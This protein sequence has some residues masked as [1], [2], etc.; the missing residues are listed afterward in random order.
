LIIQL[1][2]KSPFTTRRWFGTWFFSIYIG[3]VI[4]PTEELIFFR[5]IETTNQ[6]LLTIINHIIT[7]NINQSTNIIFASGI[8]SDLPVVEIDRAHED[9]EMVLETFYRPGTSAHAD[10][11]RGQLNCATQFCD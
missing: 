1:L 6:I 11:T 8:S 2:G 7:I 9:A 4:I 10:F 3:N 5:G